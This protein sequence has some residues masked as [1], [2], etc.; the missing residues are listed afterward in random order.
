[1]NINSIIKSFTSTKVLIVGDVMIDSYMWGEINKMSP[2]APVPIVEINNIENRLGG[3]ANVALNI[4]ALGAKPTLCSVIGECN[5]KVTFKALMDK[6]NLSTAAIL[7]EDGRK[8]TK[9]TRVISSKKHQIRIDEEDIY[10][11]KDED[12]FLKIVS[13][14]LPKNDIIILQDYNKGVLTPKVIKH[15]ISLANQHNIPTIV[16]PKINNFLEYKECTVFKPNLH[17]I[18]KGM[19]KKFDDSNHNNLR[20]VSEELRKLLN[21]KA[22]LLTLSK[23]GIFINTKEEYKHINAINRTIIDV[24]GAGDT[25]VSVAALCLANNINY[26]DLAIISNIA[27]GIVCE[28]IGVVAIEKDKLLKELKLYN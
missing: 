11:I 12:K 9:K 16:D 28:N 24:S 5:S 15:I 1:M 3:A 14:L 8:T 6:Q 4:K 22:I 26:N 18:K 20:I 21:A 25:V 2:E 27:A 17:E 10:P 19:N 23:K 13:S 7:S